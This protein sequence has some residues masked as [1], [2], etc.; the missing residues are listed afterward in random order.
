MNKKILFTLLL[1][2]LLTGCQCKASSIISEEF[3][4]EIIKNEKSLTVTNNINNERIIREKDKNLKEETIRSEMSLSE[5]SLKINIDENNEISI[6]YPKIT[7]ENTDLIYLSNKNYY[8]D[9]NKDNVEEEI[10]YYT[11]F[12]EDKNERI[13][14]LKI[15]NE[16]YLEKIDLYNPLPDKFFIVQD[17]NNQSYIIIGTNGASDDYESQWFV[18]DNSLKSIGKSEMYP[19]FGMHFDFKENL[20]TIFNRIK[21]FETNYIKQEYKINKKYIESKE[22]YCD[23]FILQKEDNYD[24]VLKRTDNLKNKKDLWIN[25][26]PNKNS[27]KILLPKDSKFTSTKTNNKHFVNIIYNGKE[28]WLYL[29]NYGQLPN[30]NNEFVS[31]IIDNLILAD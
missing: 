23:N 25:L 20:V 21:L 1:I 19:N 11:E 7:Q 17:F 24:F 22:I 16:D 28:Y 10:I 29:E 13:A 3:P 6:K 31:D 14:H 26:Y 8:I 18:Y 2:L 15:N 27:E 4:E 9:L 30:N 5:E 12:L